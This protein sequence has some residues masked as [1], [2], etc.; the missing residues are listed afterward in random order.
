MSSSKTEVHLHDEESTR[1]EGRKRGKCTAGRR[2][3]AS[4]MLVDNLG[5]GI[6]AV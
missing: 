4:A 2:I 1:I 5:I 6:S 3:G